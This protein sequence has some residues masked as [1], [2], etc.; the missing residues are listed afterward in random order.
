MDHVTMFNVK[1][2]AHN[3]SIS[4]ALVPTLLIPV[5]GLSG[6]YISRAALKVLVQLSA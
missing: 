4:L 5:R 6:S 2:V 3:N 1:H